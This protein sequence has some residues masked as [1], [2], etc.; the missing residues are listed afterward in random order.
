MPRC[1]KCAF[2]S[3]LGECRNGRTKKTSVNYF[4]EACEFYQDKNMEEPKKEQQA[5]HT[6]KKCGRTLPLE[7]FVKNRHGYTHVCLDCRYPDRNK[8]KNTKPAPAVKGIADVSDDEIFGELERRGW[9]G[10]LSRVT[11]IKLK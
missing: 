4:D 5:T 3:D 10:E 7:Q 9:V 6:C 2:C 1:I 8:E 11:V